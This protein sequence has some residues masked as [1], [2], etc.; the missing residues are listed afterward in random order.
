MLQ[1]K[2]EVSSFF[3][4]DLVSREPDLEFLDVVVLQTVTVR[5]EE[6]PEGRF[7]QVIRIQKQ[8]EKVESS[9]EA[10]TRDKNHEAEHHESADGD[11]VGADK[12]V[13]LADLAVIGERQGGLVG[14][15]ERPRCKKS[16]QSRREKCCARQTDDLQFLHLELRMR[17]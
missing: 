13:V 5:K 3:G 17:S 9:F 2:I 12:V 8:A 7:F 1:K 11:G 14:D 6:R 15:L 16:G 10:D 4:L